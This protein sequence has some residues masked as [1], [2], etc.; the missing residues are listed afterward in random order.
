MDI[1]LLDAGWVDILKASP[2]LILL[3]AGLLRVDAA[4]ATIHRKRPSLPSLGVDRTGKMFLT[5]PDGRPWYVT[6]RSK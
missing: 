1:H 2:F 3:V 5:D 6:S 4:L